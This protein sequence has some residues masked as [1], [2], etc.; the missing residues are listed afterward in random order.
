MPWKPTAP[1]VVPVD[2]SPMSSKALAV[3]ADAVEDLSQL[4]VVHVAKH[5]DHISIELTGDAHG[6][7]SI[8]SIRQHLSD[9]VQQHGLSEAHQIVLEGRAGHEIASYADR[10]SAGLIVIPSHGYHG[11]KRMLLGSVAEQVIRHAHCPVLVVR[12]TDAE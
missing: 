1:V 9:L 5:L 4:Y 7:E 11:A 2:F 12:R 3:A 8:R 10:I 6:A